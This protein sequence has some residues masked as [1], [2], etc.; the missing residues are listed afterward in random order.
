MNKFC[1]F[2]PVSAPL[3]MA[4]HTYLTTRPAYGPP[5]TGPPPTVKPTPP[6]AGTPMSSATPPL[7]KVDGMFLFCAVYS[8]ERDNNDNKSLYSWKR[9]SF[10]KRAFTFL[11]CLC[12][13][14]SLNMPAQCGGVVNN[15][16]PHTEPDCQAE[17]I[18]CPGVTKSPPVWCHLAVGCCV[19]AVWEWCPFSASLPSYEWT[20]FYFYE[21]FHKSNTITEKFTWSHTDGFCYKS[22]HVHGKYFS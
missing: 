4:P 14:H 5:P 13:F 3:P 21:L 16:F 18:E 15:A 6:P 9:V 12:C 8:F 2:Q 17:D 10:W 1:S 7:P 11:T 20:G 22:V 19:S